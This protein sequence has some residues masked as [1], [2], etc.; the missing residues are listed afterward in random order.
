M[1]CSP[2]KKFDSNYYCQK[3]NYNCTK[4]NQL[5]L[6]KT[7]KGNF[8]VMLNG[9]NYPLTTTNFIKN[10]KN[11]I[12]VDQRFYKILKYSQ[13]KIIH[14]GTYTENNFLLGNIKKFKS[15]STQIPLEIG[16]KNKLEPKYK[17]QF[18]NP[19]EIDNLQENFEKGSLAMGKR[20]EK[21]S[22]STEFF[23]VTD[24]L[25]ELDGRYSIFGKIVKG[26]EVLDKIEEKDLIYGIEFID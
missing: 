3:L 6:F 10:V 20:G 8:E 24:K 22:S 17:Y 26:F 12:Y 7:S 16:I 23:F 18:K 9:Q 2:K 21:N 19:Y 15:L 1:S 14:A 4:E 13:V 5:V 11:N 25:P